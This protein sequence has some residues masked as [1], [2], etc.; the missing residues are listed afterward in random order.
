MATPK[1]DRI[2]VELSR[3]LNDPVVAATSNGSNI[4]AIQRN[5]FVN[6]ALMELFNLKWQQHGGDIENFTKEFPELIVTRLASLSSS[7]YTIVNPNLDFRA[8]VSIV[9]DS[10]FA[11]IRPAH[12]KNTVASGAVAQMAGSA[13]NPTEIY[14]RGKIY[15]YPTATFIA[16]GFTMDII[17]APLEP[18]TG[19]YLAQGGSTDSPYNPEWEN[20]IVE[21]AVQLF[22]KD[23]GNVR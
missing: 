10:K 11:T 3:R 18:T 21:I 9:V 20:T 14:S 8:L 22:D 19:E 1:F 2:S 16:Q 17:R 4:T 5:E 12:L 13:T 15:V 6:M 23:K 7:S